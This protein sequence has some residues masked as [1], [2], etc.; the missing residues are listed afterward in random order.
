M[1]IASN[2][3]ADMLQFYKDQLHALYDAGELHAIID[4]V[5]YH[6]LRFSKT[7]VLTR[8][9]ENLNQSDVLKL[10]DCCKLLVTGVPVQYALGEAE[11]YGLRFKVNSSVLIP[12]PETEELMD[13]IVKTENVKR[14]M[15][16][17][18]RAAR[19]NTQDSKIQDTYTGTE[20]SILD[21][22]TGS[23][24]IPV[25]L[26]KSL[27][28]AK[29]FAIDIS[30]AALE[31]ARG[32]AAL[33]GVEVEFTH[34]DIL[35]EKDFFKGVTFNLIVSNPPYIKAGEAAGMTSQVLAHEPATALFVNDPD[36]ILFYKKII[37]FCRGRL[38]KGG[39][40]YFELNPLTAEQVKEDAIASG[41]FR[42][43]ILIKDL[44]GK[45]RFLKAST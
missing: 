37:A 36:A 22:G 24:C 11:F 10:Y 4:L 32:N 34:A 19:Q 8:Q 14:K 15:E 12:R 40:L 38:V 18:E 1:K 28:Y 43:V 21:I 17:G 3:I 33:N 30:E 5:F 41:L 13:I 42:E 45:T 6:Y 7:D 44:S 20:H 27:P 31:T 29:A 16:D 9:D 23:G 25:T 26:K 2:K 39:A 35:E